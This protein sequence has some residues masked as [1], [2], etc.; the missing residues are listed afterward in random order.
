MALF[1]ANISEMLITWIVA[2]GPAVLAVSLL[3]GAV[4]LPLPGTLLVLTAGALV[5]QGLLDPV[6]ALALALLAVV[7]GDVVGYAIGRVAAPRIRG[8]LQGTPGWQRAENTLN[9][10]GGAAVFFTRWFLT[11]L[12]V[13]T[14][15]IA[16]SGRYPVS[17]YVT[18]DV[19]GELLWLVLFGGIGYVCCGSLEAINEHASQVATALVGM[20]VLVAGTHVFLQRR[21]VLVPTSR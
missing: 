18:F 1:G 9:R 17:K 2:Y 14:N 13:P 16:G 11:P 4:G 10:R 5:R 15:L 12:A 8:R 7:A 20:L 19:A 3:L 6:S 21:S